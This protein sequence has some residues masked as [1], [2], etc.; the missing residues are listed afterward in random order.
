MARTFCDID[1]KHV[2]QFLGDV[3]IDV[4][5]LDRAALQAVADRIGPTVAEL[6]DPAR[7]EPPPGETPGLYAFRAEGNFT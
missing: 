3:A 5:N 2:A 6:A 4:Y 1:P 7:R